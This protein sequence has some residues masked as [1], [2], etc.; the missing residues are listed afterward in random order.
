MTPEH[1]EHTRTFTERM[2]AAEV[3]KRH[4]AFHSDKSKSADWTAKL[5]AL[6][7]MIGT[8]CIVALYGTRGGGKTQLAVELIR[9][10]C[11]RDESALY[12]RV[13]DFFVDIKSTF[14]QKSP[15]TEADIIARYSMPRLLVL[16]EA[17]EKGGGPWENSLMNLLIDK[18]YGDRKDT[19]I[20]ANL[21]KPEL[22]LALGSSVISRINE[23]GGL[24]DCN[25]GSF[26]T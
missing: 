11:W 17:H 19:I 1:E 14:G 13:M 18:R 26:R 24:I 8:G 12:R 6:K 20:I 9:A 7:A 5:D 23:T 15:E 10:V 4:A 16:D 25:W 3:P 22:E 2:R 21:D